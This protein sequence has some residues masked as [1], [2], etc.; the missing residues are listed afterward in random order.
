[1]RDEFI[2]EVVQRMVPYL[3]NKQLVNLQ[4]NLNQVLQRYDVELINGGNSENDNQELVGKFISAKRVEGCSEKTLKSMFDT[5]TANA[6]ENL[7][8]EALRDTLLPKFMSGELDVS[9]VD[10]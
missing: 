10:I 1:M 5:I 8:L 7:R 4:N 6:S 2:S 9:E 3:D